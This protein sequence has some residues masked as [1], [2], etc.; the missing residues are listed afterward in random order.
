V[1]RVDQPTAWQSRHREFKGKRAPARPADV[2]Y[3]E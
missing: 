1:V 3:G 2:G